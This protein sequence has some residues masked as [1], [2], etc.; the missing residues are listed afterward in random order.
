[1]RR[2]LKPIPLKDLDWYK[3]VRRY[4]WDDET[5]PYLIPVSK[6]HRKQAENEIFIYCVFIVLLFAA[7]SL[8]SMTD[9][10]PYGRSFGGSL[11][12][13]SVACSGVILALTRDF[14]AAIFCALG[15]AGALAFSLSV[16]LQ[17]D[18]DLLDRGLLLVF[19][20]LWLRYALRVINIAR[21]YPEMPEP[22]PDST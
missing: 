17:P 16:N 18:M 15:P 11:F 22:P 21:A 8:I 20:V 4:F 7:I 1:M 3:F 5:T 6:L 2:R 13:F 9:R 14:F 12:A 19:S 10:A